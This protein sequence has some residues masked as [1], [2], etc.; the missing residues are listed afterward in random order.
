MNNI[1]DLR[2]AHEA[3]KKL[4]EDWEMCC[5]LANEQWSRAI[6]AEYRAWEAL[7]IAEEAA[8]DAEEAAMEAEEVQP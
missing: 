8:M 1:N 4:T 6:D 2:A 7:T 3:A 5:V